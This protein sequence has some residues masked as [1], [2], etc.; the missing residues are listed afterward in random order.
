MLK[1]ENIE[2]VMV[3]LPTCPHLPSNDCD[4]LVSACADGRDVQTVGGRQNKPLMGLKTSEKKKQ[5]N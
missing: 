5:K 4:L 1:N 3:F 2:I